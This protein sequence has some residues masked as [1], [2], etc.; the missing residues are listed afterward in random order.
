VVF[1]TPDFAAEAHGLMLCALMMMS[2]AA[3]VTLVVTWTICSVKDLGEE[4]WAAG[5][6]AAFSSVV[7]AAALLA[8]VTGHVPADSFARSPLSWA[9]RPVLPGE[10]P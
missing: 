10:A 1:A 9:G 7:L 8:V 4:W 3:F 6:G 2:A 5:V